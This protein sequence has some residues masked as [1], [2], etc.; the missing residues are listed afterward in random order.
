LRLGL[1]NAALRLAA[2]SVGRGACLRGMHRSSLLPTVAF[3]QFGHK[4]TNSRARAR[5]PARTPPESGRVEGRRDGVQAAA[6]SRIRRF[7]LR[8]RFLPS[9]TPPGYTLLPDPHGLLVS[10]ERQGERTLVARV[11]ELLNRAGPFVPPVCPSSGVG[12]GTKGSCVGQGGITNPSE[13][14]AIASNSA[15]CL[16]FSIA[17]SAGS[18]PATSTPYL[19]ERTQLCGRM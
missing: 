13:I 9:H 3:Q 6:L 7:R 18:T 1:Q 12:G 2:L 14:K 8:A 15:S 19:M 5:E 17:L 16:G 11:R 4:R 10:P